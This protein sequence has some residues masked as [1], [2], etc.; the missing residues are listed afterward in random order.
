MNICKVNL[1]YLIKLFLIWFLNKNAYIF[2][3]KNKKARNLFTF[4]EICNL[5]KRFAQHTTLVG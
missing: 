3:A 5:Q 2:R 1:K 4:D